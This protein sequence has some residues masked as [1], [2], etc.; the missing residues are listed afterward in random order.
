MAKKPKPR[1]NKAYKE[2]APSI[3][4]L[5][6]KFIR[7]IRANIDMAELQY[8]NLKIY[9]FIDNRINHS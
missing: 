7:I 8:I 4:L 3:K 2:W 9:Y 6:K 1:N 5:Q